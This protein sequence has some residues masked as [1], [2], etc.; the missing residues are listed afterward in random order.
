M[1]DT[2]VTAHFSHFHHLVFFR[3]ILTRNPNR[4][5][6]LT[7]ISTQQMIPSVLP[8]C[9]ELKSVGQVLHDYRYTW[10]AAMGVFPRHGVEAL[11]MLRFC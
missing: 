3:E 8:V 10:H 11:I 5:P 7:V 1:F 6:H 4:E 2:I 9:V